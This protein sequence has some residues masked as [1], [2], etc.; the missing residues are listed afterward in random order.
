MRAEKL[1]NLDRLC[2][3]T[4]TT[5]PWSIE[6]VIENYPKAGVKA[7]SVWRDLL[8]NRDPAQI[9]EQ[10]RAAGMEIVSLVRGGFFTGNTETEIRASLDDNRRAIDEAQCNR[11]TDSCLGLWCG[12]RSIDPAIT[13]S[14]SNRLRN[15][16][17]LRR[18]ARCEIGN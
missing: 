8:E 10:I 14:D 5:K 2:I 16:P 6:E 17:S 15:P 11:G 9:G 18:R 7:V 3:H 1:T 12:A 13:C 4:I